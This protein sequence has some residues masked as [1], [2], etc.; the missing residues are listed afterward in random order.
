MSNQISTLRHFLLTHGQGLVQLS[1]LLR[2]CVCVCVCVCE[3]CLC[4]FWNLNRFL[5]P[6]PQGSGVESVQPHHGDI[7]PAGGEDAEG[8]AREGAAQPDA[9][10]QPQQGPVQV[11]THTHTHTHTHSSRWTECCLRRAVSCQFPKDKFDSRMATRRLFFFFSLIASIE[12][13]TENRREVS[14][15]QHYQGCTARNI[16]K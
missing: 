15:Q 13:R 3:F 7:L 11:H 10:P 8:E 4:V 6:S 2:V 12:R 1:G 14:D 16:L 9:I 5:S